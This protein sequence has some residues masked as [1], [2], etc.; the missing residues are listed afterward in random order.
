[1]MRGVNEKR[2][3]ILSLTAGITLL[4]FTTSFAAE[5]GTVMYPRANTNV[6]A[7]RSV[8]SKLKGQL[9]AGQPV[10]VD[11]LRDSWY[12]VFKVTEKQR[13]EKMA[14]GYVYAPRLVDKPESNSSGSTVHEEKSARDTPEIDTE[15]PVDVK[16][17]TFRITEDGKE[18][19]FVEFNRLYTPAISGIQGKAPRIILEITNASTLRKDWAVINTG[20]RLITKIRSS[21][22][23]KTHVA[24][25]VLDMEPSKDYFVNPV[26]YENENTYSLEISEEKKM[27]LP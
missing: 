1:M 8:A 16:N 20:G 11:F 7:K 14:L 21:M 9:K 17:I 24:R 2:G 15:S 23:Y 5:W 10:K 4:I 3:I 22:N 19:L 25:I 18:L 27:Q 26:F 6:R 12:A 13:N